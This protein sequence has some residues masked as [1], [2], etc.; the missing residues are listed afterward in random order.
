M[1]AG[2]I[3]S[4]PSLIFNPNSFNEEDLAYRAFHEYG[5]FD[6]TISC[7]IVIQLNAEEGTEPRQSHSLIATCE[8]K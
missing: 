3:F 6:P 7:P 4:H 2:Q 1:G 8:R 5:N